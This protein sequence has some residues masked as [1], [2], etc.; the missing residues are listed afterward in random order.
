MKR[1]FRLGLFILLIQIGIVGQA[2]GVDRAVAPSANQIQP[3][4]VGASVPDIELKKVDGEAVSLLM[5]ISMRPKVLV[6][7]RGG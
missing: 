7:Y 1:G 5:E 6:F 4:L 3:I 2:L